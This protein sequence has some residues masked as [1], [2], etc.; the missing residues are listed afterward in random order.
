MRSKQ[1]QKNLPVTARSLETLIRLSSANAK[2]RLSSSVDDEDVETA[3]E[4]MNFVLFHEIGNTSVGP[5]NGVDSRGNLMGEEQNGR[6]ARGVA[7]SLVGDERSKRARH[8]HDSVGEAA[9]EENLQESDTSSSTLPPK[10][11]NVDRIQFLGIISNFVT[12]FSD[13]GDEC[14]IV[15][16]LVHLQSNEQDMYARLYSPSFTELVVILS[17]FEIENQVC[18]TFRICLC[19]TIL[20]FNN[21]KTLSDLDLMQNSFLFHFNIFIGDDIQQGS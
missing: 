13:E 20:S 21:T 17:E 5:S 3:I 6:R 9:D 4:L 14:P 1:N 11:A 19:R 2:A 12:R 15:D 16:L 8:E 7:T 10:L 18:F